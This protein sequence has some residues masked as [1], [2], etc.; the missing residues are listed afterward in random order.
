[1]QLST[2]SALIE[3]ADPI[4]VI[5]SYVVQRPTVKGASIAAAKL[6]RSYRSGNSS[7]L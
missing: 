3:F 2:R 5:R 4:T 7:T 1:M 6:K